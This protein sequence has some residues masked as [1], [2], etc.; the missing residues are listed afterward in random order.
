MN[1]IRWFGDHWGAPICDDAEQIAVPDGEVCPGG[2]NRTIRP[3]E[4]GLS[5][6]YLHE[7]GWGHLAWHLDCF[8]RSVGV[9]P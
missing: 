2:C 4:Q 8:L 7:K 6:P 3:G 1:S 9:K 5:I